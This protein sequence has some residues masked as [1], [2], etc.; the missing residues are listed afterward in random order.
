MKRES[1][2]P[3]VDL[4]FHGLAQGVDTVRASGGPLIPFVIT[5][6]G[7]QRSSSQHLADTREASLERALAAVEAAAR[8][9]D[10]CAVVVYDA[11]LTVSEGRFDAI[12]A[13]AMDANGRAVGLVQRY[14]PKARLRRFGT[15]GDPLVLETGVGKLRS[16]HD[17]ANDQWSNLPPVDKIDLVAQSPDGTSFLLILGIASTMPF[18]FVQR[19][20]NNYLAFAVDGQLDRMHPKPPRK[21]VEVV[22]APDDYAPPEI[23][24][25]VRLLNEREPA[26]RVKVWIRDGAGGSSRD[27]ESRQRG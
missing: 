3:V 22:L 18:A 20:L 11:Y 19:K 21:R 13:E 12:F 27:G 7:H 16:R 9:P 8:E 1:P 24:A 2:P 10:D 26:N 15:L 4:M 25:L 17:P 5:E 23:H 14:R 6:R